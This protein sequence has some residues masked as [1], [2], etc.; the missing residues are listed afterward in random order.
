MLSSQRGNILQQNVGLAA[1]SVASAATT[2]EDRA[3]IVSNKLVSVCQIKVDNVRVAAEE[4]KA[5]SV[6]KIAGKQIKLSVC[7]CW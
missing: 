4:A 1:Y 5:K 7:Y 6:G 2:K 3:K